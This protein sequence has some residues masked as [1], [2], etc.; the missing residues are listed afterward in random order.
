MISYFNYEIKHKLNEANRIKKLNKKIKKNYDMVTNVNNIKTNQSE[1]QLLKPN[2]NQNI[3]DQINKV[4]K[5]KHFDMTI[6]DNDFL[7]N[8]VNN[9][10]NNNIVNF[11]INNG[12]LEYQTSETIAHYLRPFTFNIVYQYQYKN[13]NITGI[14][15]FIRGI[16]FILQFSEKYNVHFTIQMNNHLIK[17]YLHYFFNKPDIPKDI[18]T[19]I[20]FFD[21]E[22]VKYINSNNIIDYDYID[23]DDNFS[24]CLLNLPYYN[25]DKYLYT[26]NHPDPKLISKKHID[27]VKSILKP[28]EYIN[29]LVEKMLFKLKLVKHHFITIHIRTNDDCFSNKQ[30]LDLEKNRMFLLSFIKNTYVQYKLDIF[31]LSSDNN[32]KLTIMKHFPYIKFIIHNIT[33]TCLNNNNEEG[34]IN[35]L[36]DFYTMSYSKYIFSFSVYDHGSGFSKWC[37]MTYNIP[38]VCYSLEK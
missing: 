1:E 9:N 22:N 13:K 21:L 15:D 12:I 3:L 20:F 8:D 18:A 23:V 32:I 26:I 36:K 24:K 34:L 25:K 7:N 19:E 14:G 29:Y 38:Y 5:K 33:H 2:V 37:A 4:V 17:K 28:T 16:Y 30:S 35:T 31:I 11:K 27:F 6:N 10:I